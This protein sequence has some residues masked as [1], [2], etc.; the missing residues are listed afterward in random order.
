MLLELADGDRFEMVGFGDAEGFGRL[1]GV[2]VAPLRWVRRRRFCYL[3]NPRD[4]T[5]HTQKSN[6][7]S[8]IERGCK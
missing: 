4:A 3:V 5:R 1:P 8:S 7:V 2:K 6:T